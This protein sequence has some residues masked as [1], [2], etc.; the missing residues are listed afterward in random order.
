MGIV[1]NTINRYP[2]N[3][4]VF[5]LKDGDFYSVDATVSPSVFPELLR[6][7]VQYFKLHPDKK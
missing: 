5:A 1:A 3:S 7:Y 4:P 2:G 6:L